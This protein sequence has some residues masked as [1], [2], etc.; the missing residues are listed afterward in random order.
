MRVQVR[1]AGRVGA[2]IAALLS[3]S[4]VGRVDV[5]DGGL[6]EPWDVAP[7]GLPPSAVGERRDAS[8]RRLVRQS[9]AG[10]QPRTAESDS[11]REGS[12]PGLSLVVVAPRDGLAVYAPDPG[13]AE[14]WISAGIPHLYAGVIEATGVVGP[15]VLP[16]G[17]GCAGC[18]G[19][20]R[21][22]QDAQWPRLV[23]QWRTGRRG[24]VAGVRP[25]SVGGGGRA[26]RVARPLFPG[27]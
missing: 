17:T 2:A 24:A 25:R 23:A 3:G 13:T 5:L 26:R 15:L 21:A 9:A 10:G 4:G 19:L 6:T 27:R 16:G 1:G 8:A 12:G 20:R 11:G 14:P 18:L 7:G 22:D